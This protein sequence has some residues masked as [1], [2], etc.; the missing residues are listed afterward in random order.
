MIWLVTDGCV[1]VT[2]SPHLGHVGEGGQDRRVL[3]QKW[4]RQSSL[5][6]GR[7][8]LHGCS[9]PYWALHGFSFPKQPEVLSRTAHHGC[10]SLPLYSHIP[11]PHVWPG[12]APL[13]GQ[14]PG[15]P[16]AALWQDYREGISETSLRCCTTAAWAFFCPIQRFHFTWCPW[17]GCMAPELWAVT[18]SCQA[19]LPL[20]QEPGHDGQLQHR[21]K[22]KR[23]KC[24]E[25]W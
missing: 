17:R 19:R 8:A 6:T 14:H 12:N 25:G 20:E 21:Q 24:L 13:S 3:Y 16:S 7:G 15:D 9:S 22:E 10:V 11:I 4:P 1:E 5:G 2:D 23:R 18:F